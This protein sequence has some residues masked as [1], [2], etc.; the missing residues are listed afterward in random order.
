[1][2]L[3]ACLDLD[4]SEDSV[5]EGEVVLPLRLSLQE[6]DRLPAFMHGWHVCLGSNRRVEDDIYVV[7]RRLG[8]FGPLVWLFGLPFEYFGD[9][10]Q[11]LHNERGG[12][13]EGA[14]E[15][16]EQHKDDE[17]ALDTLDKVLVDCA[18]VD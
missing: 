7:W 1:M 2:L 5:V 12:G 18:V 15:I 3:Y 9:G 4:D 14:E 13:C 6:G 8:L 16:G 10:L 11:C 17:R